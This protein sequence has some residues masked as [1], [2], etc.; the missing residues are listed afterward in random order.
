MADF[1]KASVNVPFL[2]LVNDYLQDSY[3]VIIKRAKALR[4]LAIDQS[5]DY[6]YLE[7]YAKDG[8]YFR[9]WLKTR[10]LASIEHREQLVHDSDFARAMRWLHAE[11][12]IK[13]I[14]AAKLKRKR[15]ISKLIGI[16]TVKTKGAVST[17]TITALAEEIVKNRPIEALAHDPELSSV[18]LP[19]ADE[20][21]LCKNTDVD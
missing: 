18:D 17:E 20:L 8:S 4:L 16:W 11:E 7:D 5:M 14:R 10:W 9:L 6:I 15:A 12:R 13:A 1:S 21:E 19:T 2:E 3:C